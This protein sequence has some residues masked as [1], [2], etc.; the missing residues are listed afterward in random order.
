MK[1]NNAR[2]L[3]AVLIGAV[4][5]IHLLLVPEYLGEQPYL[6]MLFAA[7]TA[8]CALISM[9]LWQS[10]DTASWVFG[11]FVVAG[12]AIGFVLSRT[13][14]LPGFHESDWELS[15]VLS[16]LL[17][18]LFIAVAVASLRSRKHASLRASEA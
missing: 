14:G 5:T 6:G 17:E 11:S 16:L 18:L 4:G 3:A 2:R 7:G 10:E 12:M 15:G 13:V 1:G 9:R 8:G